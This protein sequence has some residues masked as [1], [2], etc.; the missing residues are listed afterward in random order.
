MSDDPKVWTPD[1]VRSVAQLLYGKG[2]QTSLALAIETA[3]RRN[4]PQSRI[5]KWFLPEGGRGIP[6]WLQ[7]ELTPIL[8]E[9]ARM[10]EFALIDAREIIGRH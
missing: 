3:T 2:W 10:T 7:P 4:F 9:V 1:E 6:A 8:S 5:A